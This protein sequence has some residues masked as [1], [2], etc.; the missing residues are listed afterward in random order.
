MNMQVLWRKRMSGGPQSSPSS[1]QMW[2]RR[3]F[4]DEL[5]VAKRPGLMVEDDL[6]HLGSLHKRIH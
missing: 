3:R 6:D 1:G 5:D 4:C 2:A